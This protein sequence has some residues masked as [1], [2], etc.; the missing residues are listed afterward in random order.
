MVQAMR[1]D[2]VLNKVSRETDAYSYYSYYSYYHYRS[3]PK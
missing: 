2:V 3:R 1:V